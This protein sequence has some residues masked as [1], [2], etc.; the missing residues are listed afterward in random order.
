MKCIKCYNE[1]I[2]ENPELTAEQVSKDIFMRQVSG[3]RYVP[4]L[5]RRTLFCDKCGKRITSLETIVDPPKITIEGNDYF[6]LKHIMSIVEVLGSRREHVNY[7]VEI[8]DKWIS[9]CWQE[10]YKNPTGDSEYAK[11]V[12]KTIYNITRFTYEELKKIESKGKQWGI[13]PNCAT[14]YAC[15]HSFEVIRDCLV[16]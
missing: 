6:E 12:D 10:A 13:D 5:Q 4:L 16:K 1:K 14:K 8:V 7:A 9:E 2:K 15:K 11:V 3:Q